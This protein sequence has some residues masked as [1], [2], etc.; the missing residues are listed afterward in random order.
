M[1]DAGDKPGSAAGA[2]IA[3]VLVDLGGTLAS[4][5]VISV[6][7]ALS[8]VGDSKS[9]QEIMEAFTSLPTDSWI[10]LLGMVVGTLFSVAGGYICAR[11]ARRR[12]YRLPAIVA[13]VSVALGLIIGGDHYPPLLMAWLC[14]GTV[15]AVMIGA[16][17]AIPRNEQRR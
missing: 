15:V 16:W 2:V 8:L 4:S 14:A 11:I 10:Q 13:A 9:E 17:L 12:D 7:Y 5:V 1:Q 6:I 3:G